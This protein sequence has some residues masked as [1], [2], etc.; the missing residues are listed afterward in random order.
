M[1]DK[2]RHYILVLDTETA[3]TLTTILPAIF[4]SE[5]ELLK[6]ERHVMDMSN[7]LVYDCGW[8]VVD[9]HGNIYETASFINK[10]IFDDECELMQSAYYGWKVP[11]YLEGI[12]NGSHKKKNTWEIRQAMFETI[13]KYNIK[14]WAAYNASFDSKALDNT[15]RYHTSSKYRYWFPFGS[16]DIWDI[17]KMARDVIAPMPTFISFCEKNGFIAGNGKPRTSAEIVYRF[18]INDPTFEESHTGLEDVI[19][20]TAIMAYCFRQHKKMRKRLY[21]N[22]REIYES[23]IFQKNFFINLKQNPVIRMA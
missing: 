10:D 16:I 11:L 19:I 14:E 12:K 4:D 23:N 9:T 3:N 7:V 18:I 20:E 1:I 21:D 5:G 8:A 15:Q 17:M 6:P 22:E 2:R 13:E